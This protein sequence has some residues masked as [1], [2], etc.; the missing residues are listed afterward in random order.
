MVKYLTDDEPEEVLDA[1][2]ERDE[3]EGTPSIETS[4]LQLLTSGPLSFE[5]KTQPSVAPVLQAMTSTDVYSEDEG[6]TVYDTF[7]P[8]RTSAKPTTLYTEVVMLSI[9][10]STLA[11]GL[12]CLTM[13][14]YTY[15]LSP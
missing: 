8:G 4:I 14:V 1:E 9:V 15:P 12:V 13:G 2:S 3:H 11:V 6:T 7:G 10:V 5:D